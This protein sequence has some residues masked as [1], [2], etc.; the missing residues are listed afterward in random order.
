MHKFLKARGA[1][2]TIS[3]AVFLTASAFAENGCNEIYD[4]SSNMTI[5]KNQWLPTLL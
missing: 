5:E 4:P 3:I 2:F 1:V